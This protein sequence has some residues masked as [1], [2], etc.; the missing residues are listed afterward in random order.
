MSEKQSLY[1]QTY[2][3]SS[4]NFSQQLIIYE[5]TDHRIKEIEK[6]IKK[7]KKQN[8]MRKRVLDIL[9]L[10][11]GVYL[12]IIRNIWNTAYDKNKNIIEYDNEIIDD[13]QAFTI[14]TTNL[15]KD[16]TN[17]YFFHEK[18]IKEDLK[19]IMGVVKNFEENIKHD[20]SFY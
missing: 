13:K 9:S 15:Y 11:E 16:T 5:L 18:N 2:S 7:I 6:V 8:K 10:D 14:K 12:D 19:K 3:T 4:V 1:I 17:I 20:M